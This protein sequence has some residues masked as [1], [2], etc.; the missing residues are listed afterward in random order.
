M[1][2]QGI[3]YNELSQFNLYYPFMP[4]LFELR[5]WFWFWSLATVGSPV[6]LSPLQQVEGL[7]CY[8]IQIWTWTYPLLPDEIIMVL[9]MRFH[10]LLIPEGVHVQT[11]GAINRIG[12]RTRATG[13]LLKEQPQG[14][15][16][17]MKQHFSDFIHMSTRT[18]PCWPPAM[19]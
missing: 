7:P 9:V 5:I 17:Q 15:R 11:A 16:R 6:R 13:W 12:R 1:L 14:G 8:G 3:K 4:P 10:R 19:T 18:A 2:K